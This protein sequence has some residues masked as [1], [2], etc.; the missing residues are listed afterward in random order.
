MHGRK[1]SGDLFRKGAL[2]YLDAGCDPPASL[3]EEVL[4]ERW[5]GQYEKLHLRFDQRQEVE[6][7]EEGLDDAGARPAIDASAARLH[8]SDQRPIDRDDIELVAPAAEELECD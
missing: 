2:D 6:L 8:A 3:P 7:R 4:V 5:V 1:Q